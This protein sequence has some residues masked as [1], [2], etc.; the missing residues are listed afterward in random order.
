MAAHFAKIYRTRP[1][2]LQKIAAYYA[3]LGGCG[4]ALFAKKY[5]T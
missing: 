2:I 4:T 1:H 3:F 5:R